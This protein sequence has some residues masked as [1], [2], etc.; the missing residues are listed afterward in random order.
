VGYIDTM[1]QYYL[2]IDPNELTDEEWSIK[3]KQIVDIRKRENG[4]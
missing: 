3:F 1:L 2:G 4:K